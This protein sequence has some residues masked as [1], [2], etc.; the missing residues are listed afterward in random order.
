MRAA[1]Q[2]RARHG[3]IGRCL[4]LTVLLASTPAAPSRGQAPA[5]LLAVF[6]DGRI[7]PVRGAQLVGTDRLRLDLGDAASIEVPLARID[8]VIEDVADPVPESVPAPSCRPGYEAQLLP[9]G[10][11]FA[12]A[13][14]EAGRAANLHPWLVAAVVE[15]ESR[16]NPAAVSR[17]GAAGLMQLMP[18]VW[19]AR[20][21]RD[22]F[23]V[24]P[25]LRAGCAHLRAL[26]E[27]YGDIELALAAYNAGAATVD[28]YRGLPPFR[29]TR[30]YVRA[31]L[32][33]FCPGDATR[34][35]GGGL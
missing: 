14:G 34:Q 26:L 29:E 33:K 11:P 3:R 4:L 30:R 2:T 8:R 13:I 1:R 24:A 31:I 18:S 10:T 35:G 19:A 32:A 25:N 6:V 27:R 5:P 16:F 20:G 12:D 17:V 22:P 21:V 7:L 9:P 23:A 28:R 15:A